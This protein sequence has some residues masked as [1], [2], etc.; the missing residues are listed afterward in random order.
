MYGV[1]SE[2]M[3]FRCWHLAGVEGTSGSLVT[4]LSRSEICSRILGGVLSPSS[5][6]SHNFYDGKG[7]RGVRSPLDR[8]EQPSAD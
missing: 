3:L 1:R 5:P 6:T 2:A 7:G 8:A 4:E